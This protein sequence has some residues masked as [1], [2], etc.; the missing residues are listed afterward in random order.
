MEQDKE[1][2]DL[3]ERL[4]RVEQQL[5]VKS[6]FYRLLTIML[7]LIVAMVILNILLGVYGINF[8]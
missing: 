3:K 6:R 7:W 8:S 1:L 5:Q 2:N 4:A